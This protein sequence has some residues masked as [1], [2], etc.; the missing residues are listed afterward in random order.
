MS[1]IALDLKQ[2]KHL[3][4]T[5]DMT[6]LQHKDGHTLTIAHKALSPE[7]QS[8]LS[9]LSKVGPA[10]QTPDQAAQSR[11]Q[12]MAEGGE[13]ESPAKPE[14]PTLDYKQ[15]KKEYKDKNFSK[16]GATKMD[17]TGFREETKEK[18]RKKFANGGDVPQALAPTPDA[19]QDAPQV[20]T[21]I[22]L[23]PDLDKLKQQDYQQHVDALNK[24]FP[25]YDPDSID[26][27]AVHAMSLDN[28]SRDNDQKQYAQDN[29]QKAQQDQ[30]FAQQKQQLTGIQSQS[31]PASTPQAGGSP[32]VPP[33]ANMPSDMQSDSQPQDNIFGDRAYGQA[34]QKGL[35]QQE[36]GA[37][38]E[39]AAQG[40][41]G[42]KQA[43]LEGEYQQTAQRAQE[44]YQTNMTQ[45]MNEGKSIQQDIA[46]GHLD[47]NHYINSMSTGGHIATGIGLLL[48]GLGSGIAGQPNMMMDYLTKQIDRDIDAQKTELGK[49]QNLLSNNI[50]QMGNLRAG[51]ELT[52]LQNQEI[53]QARLKQAADES[54]DPMAKSRALQLV[55]QIEMKKA[56]AAHQLAGTMAMNT[57]LTGGTAVPS[58]ILNRLPQETRERAV[59][60]PNGT[61]RV[62]Y[63][64]AG[65]EKIRNQI[66]T[67]QPI[68]DGLGQLD[69][70]GPSA[71]VPGSP[72]N[73]KARGVMARLIP[74]V[75]E[76]ADLKRL[77]SEDIQN[78]NTMLSDPTKLSDR[79]SGDIKNKGFRSFLADKL[80]SS[81]KNQLIGGAPGQSRSKSNI[82]F[83]PNQ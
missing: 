11:D 78:I 49:K 80:D 73:L 79:L 28:K 75:N 54:Q 56:E 76:N 71:M 2:F 19:P 61:L 58:A 29:A 5:P 81:M 33:P 38:N 52:R 70:I 51:T 63:D 55:G 31:G 7:A 24:A 53:L 14:G 23:H 34:M 77:S 18:N 59:T 82:S 72:E 46:N 50:A 36:V 42:T 6:T 13:V 25:G 40:A 10:A 21:S 74:M 47:P 41:L 8:Q 35:N 68:L 43:G 17:Y 83:T 16:P 37:V 64:K 60:M 65:A 39:Q 9:S 4:S 15:I 48:S 22:D 20:D 62:A 32:S 57:A 27:M 66:E 44:A 1:K 3:H 45:L 69:K 67:T 12:K 26:K 30:Q